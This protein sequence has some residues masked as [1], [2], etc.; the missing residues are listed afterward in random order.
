MG[1]GR[2]AGSTFALRLSTLDLPWAAGV[3]RLRRLFLRAGPY[4]AVEVLLPG[5]TLIAL[6][7]YLYRRRFA[8]EMSKTGGAVRL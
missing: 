6:T 2:A 7:L 8:P 5:G 1:T 3:E 4:L